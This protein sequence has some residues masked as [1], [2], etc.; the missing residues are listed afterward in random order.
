VQEHG[1]PSK[2]VSVVDLSSNEE[3]ALPDTLQDEEFA[4]RLF[5]DLNRGLLGPPG[6]DNIIFLSDSDEE[7][8]V[9]EEDTTDIEAAP[10]SAANTPALTISTADAH[11]APEGVQD[12]NSD[13]EDE[14]GSP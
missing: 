7:E 8:E 2:E 6:D 13:G 10:P 5:G 1:G 11:N 14:A 12:A 4:R 9:R 3:D